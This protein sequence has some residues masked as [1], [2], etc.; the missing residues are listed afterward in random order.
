MLYQQYRPA[1]WDDFVGQSKAVKAIRRIIERDGFDRGAF[2]IEASGANNSG[3][4]KT[5]LAWIIARQLADDFFITELDGSRCDKRAV[6]AMESAARLCAWSTDKPFKVWVINE[7]H[8]MTQGAVDALLTFLES[9]PKHCVVIFTTT[10]RVDESLFGDHDSGPFASRCHCVTLTNQGLA[11]A[12]AERAQWIAQR[13]GLDGQPIGAYVKLVQSCKNNMR[14]VL[15][16]I[17][18]GDMLEG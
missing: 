8:A 9:L 3:V 18:A 14:A 7:A 17:E 13:E 16:R 6:E 11:Q 1:T 4:G 15:Q 2:W 12:F 10:R 5:T